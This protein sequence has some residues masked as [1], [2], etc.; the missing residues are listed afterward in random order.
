[1]IAMAI[2]AKNSSPSSGDMP[3]MV[4]TD[5]SS[6]DKPAGARAHERI[7]MHALFRHALVD[8]VGE[9][10]AVLDE[11]AC[12]AQQAERRRE[13]EWHV[14]CEQRKRHA[15]DHHGYGEPD[16]QRLSQT[17]EHQHRDQEHEAE[18][19]GSWRRASLALRRS[20]RIRRPIRAYSPAAVEWPRS[21]VALLRRR[22]RGSC[23]AGHCPAP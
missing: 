5:A 12:E 15:A 10:D 20:I 13:G 7:G 23:R 11:H 4:V 18:G 3:A 1:M 8:L 19:R 14:C 22:L 21:R 16:H 2:S 17:A 9:H 6:T